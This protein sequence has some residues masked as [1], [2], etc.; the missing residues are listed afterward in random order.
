MPT[1]SSVVVVDGLLY[2]VTDAGIASCLDEKT[3]TEIW[4][5]RI[6]GQYSA[7]PLYAG[8]RIYFFSEDGVA[9]VLAAGREFKVLARNQLADGF[10]AS[11]A[12]SGDSLILRT[13]AN[14]YRI[15]K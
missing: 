3:G 12:V 4:H 1:R 7:S 13:R 14:V 9:T 10:M 6:D 2:M 15:E 5:D 11:A 8:G